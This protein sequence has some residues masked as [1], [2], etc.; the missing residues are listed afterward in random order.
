ME[1]H[2][3]LD[4]LL[5]TT[6]DL[7]QRFAV[8]APRS[9]T[10][11]T[12]GGE[13]AVQIGHLAQC[14]L[15]TLDAS[16]ADMVAES[17]RPIQQIGDELADVL[18]QVF[19]ILVLRGDQPPMLEILP[20]RADTQPSWL[21]SFLTLIAAS[22]QLIEE[23]LVSEGFRHTRENQGGAPYISARCATIIANSAQLA[24]DHQV[25]LMQDFREMAVDAAQFV[26]R[27]QEQV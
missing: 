22:G 9:W 24:S 5:A 4:E 10:A 27:W 14:L 15:R 17:G 16:A 13:L 3:N 26:Q 25:D 2:L 21:I 18:L 23:L 11:L 7:R 19:S 20:Q 1:Q 6:A 8:T 12:A